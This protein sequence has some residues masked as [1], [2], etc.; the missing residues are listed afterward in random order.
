VCAAKAKGTYYKEKYYRLKARLGA[1][2]AAMAIA[3]KILVAVFHRLAEGTEF[4]ELGPAHLDRLHNSPLKSAEAATL[5][6]PED[7]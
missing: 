1:K 6:P 7:V 5:F 2:R 3:H 4:R